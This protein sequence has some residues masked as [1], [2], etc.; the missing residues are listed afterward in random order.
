MKTKDSKPKSKP[1]KKLRKPTQ[2]RPSNHL[3]YQQSREYYGVVKKG[4]IEEFEPGN[5]VI[6]KLNEIDVLRAE[7]PRAKVVKMR[8][9]I[10]V[11]SE[12]IL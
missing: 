8:M 4:K 6:Y 10:R 3:D 9:T 2:D 7:Y 1:L 11:V 12:V 5:P